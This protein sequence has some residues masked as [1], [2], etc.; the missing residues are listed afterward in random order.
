MSKVQERGLM[1]VLG[2]AEG[3]AN[4]LRAMSGGRLD[5]QPVV[6]SKPSGRFDMSLSWEAAKTEAAVI[7]RGDLE[8][9]LSPGRC[10]RSQI[11][12]M[13]A[14]YHDVP[15]EQVPRKFSS[16][17]SPEWVI[18][19]GIAMAADHGE[20]HRPMTPTYD[21][22]GWWTGWLENGG[23]ETFCST[24]G[25]LDQPGVHSQRDCP[26]YNSDRVGVTYSSSAP[27]GRPSPGGAL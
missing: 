13:V 1:E 22:D 19:C 6:R 4:V 17:G 9:S 10:H 21:A 20:M 26:R 5:L 2:E 11:E 16:G 8:R 12:H 3:M 7:S 14:K 23:M 15:W 25:P 18:V 24:C 27:T